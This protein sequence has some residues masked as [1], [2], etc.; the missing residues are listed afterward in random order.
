MLGVG[1]SHPQ[2]G[3]AVW[4]GELETAS[5]TY[6]LSDIDPLKYEH[7]H[8]HQRVRSTL[9][10]EQTGE[11]KEGFGILETIVIGRHAPSGF[12]EFFDGAK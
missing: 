6:D 5:E 9:R 1:Y 7:I 10:C 2:W 12:E 8:T 11:T 4:Q 3:H